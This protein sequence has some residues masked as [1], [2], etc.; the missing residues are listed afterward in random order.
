MS[1]H[2][3]KSGE[4]TT[5]EHTNFARFLFGLI[6]SDDMIQYP[7]QTRAPRSVICTKSE[8]SFSLVYH[9]STCSCKPQT[10]AQ[11]PTY[12]SDMSLL[13]RLQGGTSTVRKRVSGGGEHDRAPEGSDPDDTSVLCVPS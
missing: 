1:R 12:I 7:F 13:S 11:S 5:I 10:P 8:A 3:E 2:T 9:H 4:R 6:M